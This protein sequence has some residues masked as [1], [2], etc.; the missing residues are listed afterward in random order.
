MEGAASVEQKGWP[1]GD[2]MTLPWVVLAVV[3]TAGCVGG[4]PDPGPSPTAS[5]LPTS[6]AALGKGF[7]K[8]SGLRLP[9]DATGLKVDAELLEGDRPYYRLRYETT[10]GGAEVACTADNFT[11]YPSD[12]PPDAEQREEF[13]IGEHRTEI[14]ETV[15]CTG[16]H[17]T[18]GLVQRGVL[19]VF[20]ADGAKRDDGEP[21][22][23]DTAMVYAYASENPG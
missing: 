10:R 5:P 11:F 21:D 12:G 20:P 7:E 17:P 16:D 19:V 4:E 2:R 6:T 3:L 15:E 9:E 8:L 22:G 23:E 13:S 1:V 18:N 14:A